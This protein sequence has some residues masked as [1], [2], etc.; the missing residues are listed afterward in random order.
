MG[1]R[2]TVV[3]WMERQRAAEWLR[4]AQAA[5]TAARRPRAQAA[6]THAEARALL[7]LTARD[8]DAAE[9]AAAQLMGWAPVDLGRPPC[10]G[11]RRR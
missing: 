9:T 6:L 11:P 4:L 3:G 5:Y 8:L 2:A 7:A 10:P 1:G